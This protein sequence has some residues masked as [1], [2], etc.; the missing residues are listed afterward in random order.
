MPAALR[1]ASIVVAA[2]LLIAAGPSTL[3]ASTILFHTDAQLIA[4]SARVVHG[5]VVAQRAVFA[6]VTGRTIYTVTT[7]Q[8]I[9]DLTAM[10]GDVVE[11]WELGGVVGGERLLV[12]GAV[13]FEYGQEVVVCLEQGPLGYRSVAMGLSKFD[14]L[15]PGGA[16]GATTMRRQIGD[17]LVVGGAVAAERSFE[18]F[19]GLVAKVTGRQPR[20]ADQAATQF[21]AAQPFASIG[22]PPI[23]WRE[24]DQRI[25]IKYYR[26]ITAPAPLV[27]GDGVAEI[28]IGLAAWTDPLAGSIILQYG[29]TTFETDPRGGWSNTPSA[30]SAVISFEDPNNEIAGA[31]LAL[32]GSSIV[33]GAGGSIGATAFDGI[34]S[35]FVIF[36]NA[37]DLPANFRQP[38][39]FTRIF[40]HEV[41]HTIG[42]DH[43]PLDGTVTNPARNVMFWNCCSADT[44]IPPALGN[45]DLLGLNSVYP[46]PGF[47]GPTMTLDRSILRFGAVT[48]GS[49]FVAATSP[50]TVA[51]RQTGSGT[52]TWTA[53]ATRPW[54]QVTPASGTGPATL[55]VSVRPGGVLPSPGSA[56]GAISLAFSGASN[57]P[58][59]LAVRL[60]A[61]PNGTSLPAIRC[62]RH[63][64]GRASRARPDRFPLP[65]GLS[66]T[67]RSIAS[68]SAGSPSTARPRPSMATAAATPRSSSARA[69]S[70]RGRGRTSRRCF[71]ASRGTRLAAGASSCSAIRCLARATAGSRSISMPT[72]ASSASRGSA[73]DRSMPTTPMR[74]CRSA[75]STRR[76]R[77]RRSAA[78]PM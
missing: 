10:P 70:S 27:S 41:G 42:F 78:R 3:I 9:E 60:S 48:L 33:S 20:R 17:A 46:W 1:L 21:V 12:G 16:A 39:D 7:I 18:E 68:P 11:V 54:L 62:R 73:S 51:L 31:V 64:G 32:G 58:G 45:D 49:S 71:R 37:A 25:P 15:R 77:V 56:E 40:M 72:I 23:R 67:S 28:N 76:R 35:G 24:A 65:D 29:G 66:T 8:V 5:R 47:S 34:V 63:A 38:Q 59:P 61:M 36:Q 2:A 43:T 57:V 6:G 74:R 53:T 52:V 22:N 14:V 19:R 30:A 55:T 50:Q 26:N 13:S 75:R 4:R 69:C 44:P